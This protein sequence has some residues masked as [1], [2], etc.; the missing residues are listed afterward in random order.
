M[1]TLPIEQLEKHYEYFKS[2]GLRINEHI[3]EELV[4]QVGRFG[5]EQPNALRFCKVG[6]KKQFDVYKNIEAIGAG[7]VWEYQHWVGRDLYILG[8]NYR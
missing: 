1:I 7:E 5:L 8:C 4:Y 3:V 2:V 6:D